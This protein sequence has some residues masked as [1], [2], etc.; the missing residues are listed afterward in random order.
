MRGQVCTCMVELEPSVMEPRVKVRER[1]RV[2][3]LFML[4]GLPGAQ[5]ALLCLALKGTVTQDF[6]VNL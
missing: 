1:A 5:H 3:I 4:M 6:K 2:S